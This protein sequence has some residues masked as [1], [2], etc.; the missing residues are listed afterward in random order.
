MT[1]VSVARNTGE[2]LFEN[3]LSSGR[4]LQVEIYEDG[5]WFYGWVEPII[6]PKGGE[7]LIKVIEYSCPREPS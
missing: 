2:V 5:V 3:D 4:F 6:V 7:V 1:R